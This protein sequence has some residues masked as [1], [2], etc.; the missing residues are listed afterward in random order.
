MNV[1]FLT[2]AR[3]VSDQQSYHESMLHAQNKGL[4]GKYHNIPFY[5]FTEAYG[6]QALW[7]EV[8]KVCKRDEMD[9][10]FFQFFHGTT[11]ESA[12]QCVNSLRKLPVKPMIA[13]SCGDLYS[14]R[15]R[16]PPAVFVEFSILADVTFLTSMGAFADYLARQGARRLMFMPHAFSNTVFNMPK[17]PVEPH[18]AEFDVVMVASRQRGLNPFKYMSRASWK[19]QKMVDTLYKRFGRRF[20]VF[21][22]GWKNHPAW[23][24]PIPF[25][26]QDAAFR[27]G[28]VVVDGR[29]PFPQTYYA[30]DRPFYI[31]G[32]GVPLV[33]H[34]TP[35]FE[36]IF[37]ENNHAYY[38]YRD[39]DVCSV[40][41]KVLS[42]DQS[43]LWHSVQ[44]TLQLV[45]ERHT[46]DNRVEH[47]IDVCR[48]VR[49]KEAE[50]T[51][52][53]LCANIDLPYFLPDVDLNEERS[54]AMVNW[55]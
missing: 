41:D 25:N 24:G 48:Q 4:I 22:H 10:V 47:I 40:C 30:S 13:I 53:E 16:Q 51:D 45:A 44:E 31:A 5:G 18:D 50:M 20:A 2:Q 35:R 11:I 23:Q 26:E 37:K 42:M 33:Q 14:R 6:W 15:Y 21:G 1:L 46:V 3:K 19:R 55:I 7:D 52:A 27:R 29:P 8:V 12:S 38:I 36:K 49:N 32:S 9:I 39:E 54:Y 17:D 28:R 34:Y 43:E